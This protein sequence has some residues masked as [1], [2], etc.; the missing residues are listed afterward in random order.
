MYVL[1]PLRQYLRARA[2]TST[3][4]A[5]VNVRNYATLE[6]RPQPGLNVFVGANAQGKSNLLEAIAPARNGQ[7]V[8]HRARSARSCAK[9]TERASVAG[10]AR[11]AA[12][13]CGS[14]A[15]L[16]RGRERHAQSATRSTGST[17]ATRGYLGTLR[18][19]TFVPAHL[20]LVAGAPSLRRAFLNAALAQESPSYYANLA[21]LRRHWRKRTRCCAAASPADGD[22]ARHL[23]RAARRTRR[24]PDAGPSRLSSTPWAQARCGVP[25]LDRGCGR[26]TRTPLRAERAVRS[27]TPGGVESAFARD[28]PRSASAETRAK[29]AW[30]GRIA[31]TSSSASTR[32]AG[33]VRIAR[34]AAHGSA[35][36]EGR[37]VRVDVDCA[38]GE[39]PILLLD[40]V[41]SEL[42]P[43]RQRAFLRAVSDV[44]QAFITTTS[45]LDVPVAATYR[46]DAAT[47]REVA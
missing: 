14:R 4:L 18:V 38:S 29:T 16:E 28:L 32:A 21:S 43:D 8:S 22:S 45:E 31:T 1:M 9:A 40:D 46:V 24:E 23:R 42:D 11:V 39:A 37:R 7:V 26:R 35:R 19:V 6:F 5:L 20:Q 12:G 15:R 3:R 44:E 30:S 34:A 13:T 17:S 36:A 33:L 2:V 25:R 10:E 27:A 47:S 41:L